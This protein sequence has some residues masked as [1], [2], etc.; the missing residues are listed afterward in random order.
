MKDNY[1]VLFI[2]LGALTE[3]VFSDFTDYK[4]RKPVLEKL[5][6]LQDT[7]KVVV[8]GNQTNRAIRREDFDCAAYSIGSFIASYAN[9]AVDFRYADWADDEKRLLPNVWLLEEAAMAFPALLGGKDCWKLVGMDEKE[10][11]DNFGIEY[12]DLYDFAK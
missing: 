6:S 3:G 5:R 4:L 11:A 10:I 12:V 2:T 7:Y 8:I 9:K 1:K